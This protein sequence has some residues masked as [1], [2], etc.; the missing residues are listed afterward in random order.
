MPPVRWQNPL[1]AT[2]KGVLRYTVSWALAT[3]AARETG[4]HSALAE[5]TKNHVE[6]IC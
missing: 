4:D 6:S 3:K 5:G 1:L 2:P